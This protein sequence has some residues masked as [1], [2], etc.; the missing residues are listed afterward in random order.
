MCGYGSVCHSKF[1]LE[2]EALELEHS[3]STWSWELGSCP[4]LYRPEGLR[5][6]CKAETEPTSSS[7][8]LHVAYAQQSH[9][10]QVD[11]VGVDLV[12]VDFVGN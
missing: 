5:R 10:A 11:F 12:G 9:C 7:T 3:V 1:T 4:A 8:E 2:A 6:K